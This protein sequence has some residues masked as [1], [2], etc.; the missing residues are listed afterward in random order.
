[1]T[2]AAAKI[3]YRNGFRAIKSLLKVAADPRVE[4]IEGHGMDDGRVFLFLGPNWVFN[5]DPTVPTNNHRSK[6]VGN[7]AE[8][9][10][11]MSIVIS[12]AENEALCNV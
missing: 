2:N 7:A 9:K 3:T 12:R 11:A 5:D 4:E 8:I 1:M 10:Y 6:S